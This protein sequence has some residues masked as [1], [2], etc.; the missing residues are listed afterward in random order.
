MARGGR[1]PYKNVV[2][3][4]Q[5]DDGPI[6]IADRGIY[7]STDAR[8]ITEELVNVRHKKRR[9]GPSDL[10]DSLA[11]WIPGCDEGFTEAAAREAPEIVVD[12][13][14]VLGKRKT[15]ASTTDPMSLFRPVKAF[16]LDELLR[17]EG[18]G[19]DFGDPK[20]AHCEMEWDADLLDERRLFKCHDC[21][22]FLQCLQCCLATHSR[23]PLHT[24]EV[25]FFSLGVARA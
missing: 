21:G 12:L 3:L 15:Y 24:L 4:D 8:R 5:D 7:F 13:A 18:L 2:D 23:T 16:F 9:V 20:C 17:H 14:T 19:D 6:Q 1:Q 10:T 11:E 25:R 22:Q